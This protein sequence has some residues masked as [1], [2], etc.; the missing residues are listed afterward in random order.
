ML[1]GLRIRKLR[2]SQ[3]R[4]QQ[5]IADVCQFSK[6]LL[7]KIEKGKTNPPVATL[8]K[9]ADA[10]GVKTS[11]LLDDDENQ[12]A[13]VFIKAVEISENRIIKTSKGYSFFTFASGRSNKTMQPYMFF[14][15]KGETSQN[16]SHK[17]EEF[18]YILEGS[19]K[20]RVGDVEY[21]LNEGDSLYFDSANEHGLTPIT[22]V[23]YLAV[24]S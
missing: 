23:K 16:L 17:G 22:D 10:L 19:M 15:K 12:N 7:S 9:I 1:L 20:F 3:N 4:T 24:F 8:M 6:S 21:L 18:I 11:D 14:A 13:T 5:E 2:L